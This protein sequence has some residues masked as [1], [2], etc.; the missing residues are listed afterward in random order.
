MSI[1]NRLK[2]RILSYNAGRNN[3]REL[4]ESLDLIYSYIEIQKVGIL[5]NDEYLLP[6]PKEYARLIIEAI[7]ELQENK[8]NSQDNWENEGGAIR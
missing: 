7:A 4:W 5:P 8:N 3:I 6:E 2:Y 1:I